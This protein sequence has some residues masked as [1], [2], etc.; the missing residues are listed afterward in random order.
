MAEED[1]FKEGVSTP[2][3]IASTDDFEDFVDKLKRSIGP[4]VYALVIVRI[5]QRKETT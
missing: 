5:D 3:P 4:D 1:R 2:V